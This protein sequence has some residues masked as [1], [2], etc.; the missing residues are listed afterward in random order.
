M[1]KSS[2]NLPVFKGNESNK[3]V[4]TNKTISSY[5]Q[6]FIYDKFLFRSVL[7]VSYGPIV[8]SGL[9]HQYIILLA[10]TNTKINLLLPFLSYD[11]NNSK[12]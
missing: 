11:I 2:K 9:S 8:F 12:R 7:F 1:W 5:I 4:D 3:S 6:T 10:F